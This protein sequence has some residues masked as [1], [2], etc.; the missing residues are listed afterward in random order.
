MGKCIICGEF[1]AELC[2]DCGGMTRAQKAGPDLLIALTNLCDELHKGRKFD[3]R[4]DY[5]LLVADAA[6]RAA[7][8]KASPSTEEEPCI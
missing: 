3:V 6:A 1:Q 7:I 5:A 8:H 2:P 4:K